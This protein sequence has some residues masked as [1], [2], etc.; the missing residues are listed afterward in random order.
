MIRARQRGGLR[1]VAIKARRID[2]VGRTPPPGDLEITEV[3]TIDSIERGVFR[4]ADI[5][6]VL[7][8]LAVGGTGVAIG[9]GDAACATCLWDNAFGE[10]GVGDFVFRNRQ[11]KEG[12]A[13]R[14]KGV[15]LS[16]S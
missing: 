13:G 16:R 11:R 14:G 10:A 15:Y 12:Q 6:A 1:R 3:F 2:S 4:A 5:G 9:A 7:R 8:P